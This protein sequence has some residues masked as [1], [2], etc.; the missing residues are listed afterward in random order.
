MAFQHLP[1]D[2][3]VM[4]TYCS[5]RSEI[6]GS[7]TA[8]EVDGSGSFVAARF[9]VGANQFTKRDRGT[10]PHVWAYLLEGT[11]TKEPL[12]EDLLWDPGHEQRKSPFVSV[13][14]VRLNLSPEQACWSVGTSPFLVATSPKAYLFIREIWVTASVDGKPDKQGRSPQRLVQWDSIELTFVHADGFR[15]HMSAAALPRATIEV[16]ARRSEGDSH[17]A[18]IGPGSRSQ[19]AKFLLSEQTIVEVQVQAQVTLRANC[20]YE[21]R[22]DLLRDDLRGAI[23]IFTEPSKAAPQAQTPT[24][25]A[26]PNA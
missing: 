13:V 18:A 25:R 4:S 14:C 9:R 3:R 23:Y 8:T 21:G 19:C 15:E 16:D 20:I 24:G 10:P 6:L 26:A 17:G 7:L 5:C 2:P 22:G 12:E 11:G 1:I